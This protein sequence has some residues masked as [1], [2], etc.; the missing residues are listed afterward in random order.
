MKKNYYLTKSFARN[1]L[2][3]KKVI[4][5]MKCLHCNHIKSL[6]NKF[7]VCCVGTSSISLVGRCDCKGF[8]ENIDKLREKEVSNK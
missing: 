7:G 3:E 1:T 2:R 6:H 4:G 8:N 5:R